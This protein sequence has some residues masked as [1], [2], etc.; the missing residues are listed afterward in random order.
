[1]MSSDL[2]S[3]MIDLTPLLAMGLFDALIEVIRWLVYILLGAIGLFFLWIIGVVILMGLGI[4]KP[5]KE[6]HKTH[7]KR[8]QRG[9]GKSVDQLADWLNLLVNELNTVSLNYTQTQIPK[10]NGNGARTLHVPNDKLKD[11]QRTIL[12][13][14]LAN[15][16]TH[17]A[18][19]GFEPGL[20]IAHNAH[21][22]VGSAVVIKLD[23][24]D[25]F[26]NSTAARVDHY[27]RR[28]GWDKDAAKILTELVTHNGGLPQGAPTSPRLSNLINY[29]LDAQ[30]QR[31][32]IKHKGTY[33]RYADDITISYPEDW[34][35]YVRGTIQ[36]VRS[37]CKR[38]GYTVH[39]R[40]KLR[41]LRRHQQQRVTG[42][43]VNEKA[44][45]PRAMRRKLRAIEHHLKTGQPATMS[46]QQLA[47][48]KSLQRMIQSQTQ[49]LTQGDAATG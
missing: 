10:R 12:R 1:M 27:F 39:T 35:K 16:K 36:K 17:D 21:A 8:A 26:P 48:W 7:R 19:T 44:Q 43:V 11:V 4:I 3:T 14:L 22:H 13:R 49:S 45:L 24:I 5:Y 30:I 9:E 23:V 2:S 40:G 15:L 32:V 20:S 31:Y 33:T 46:E 34:P 37:V 6:K 28:I 18:A 42:L 29:V 41:V 47:G 25:F 38:H